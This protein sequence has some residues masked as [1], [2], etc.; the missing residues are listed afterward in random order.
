MW[1]G[2]SPD[3]NNNLSS[4]LVFCDNADWLVE[5]V[6]DNRDDSFKI[7]EDEKCFDKRINWITSMGVLFIPSNYEGRFCTWRENDQL[8]FLLFR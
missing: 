4:P 5:M 8:R 7:A 3:H 1:H 2:C 6:S